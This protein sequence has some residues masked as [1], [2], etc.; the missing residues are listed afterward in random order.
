MGKNLL[1]TA[2]IAGLAIAAPYALGA[3]A[4]TA[5]AAGAAGAGGIGTTGLSGMGGAGGLGGAFGSAD[6]V[7]AQG[8]LGPVASPA[9]TAAFGPA[10]EFVG[11]TIES[12]GMTAN[13]FTG[14]FDSFNP[15]QRMGNE[16]MPGEWDWMK[17]FNP[18]SMMGQ[19]QQPQGGGGGGMVMRPQP[20]LLQADTAPYSQNVA[21]ISREELERI[22]RMRGLL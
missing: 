21:G 3:A 18:F 5:G 7:A 17:K 19:K 9:T 16:L 20:G 11:N 4:G 10:G 1:K 12:T 13:P 22:A 6:M 15:L 14:G 8:L 2:A